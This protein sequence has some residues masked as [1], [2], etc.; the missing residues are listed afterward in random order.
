MHK[1]TYLLWW[2]FIYCWGMMLPMSKQKNYCAQRIAIAS[3]CDDTLF[4]RNQKPQVHPDD[5][6]SIQRFRSCGSLFG[7]C[8]GRPYYGVLEALQPFVSPDFYI[9]TSGAH[10]LDANGRTLHENK[11]SR[12]TAEELWNMGT[13]FPYMVVQANGRLYSPAPTSSFQIF[14][15]N[16]SQ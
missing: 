5:L 4:F 14:V 1:F 8:T 2:Y 16:F 7:I 15:K 3:D 6:T 9:C 12:E 13:K 11:I 10:M